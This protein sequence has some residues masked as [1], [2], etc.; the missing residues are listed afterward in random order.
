MSPMLLRAWWL[1]G[2]VALGCSCSP[3]GGGSFACTSDTQC[4]PNGICSTG[5]CA[6]PDPNC[7]SQFRFGEASGPNSGNCVG[8]ANP[9]IDAAID[10]EM[11]STPDGASCY[12]SGLVRPCFASPPAG[13]RTLN[14]AIDT[15]GAMCQTTL[16]GGAGMCVIA[17]QTITITGTVT[18]SGS[19]PLVLVATGAINVST[20]DASSHTAP[21]FVGA[22]ANPTTGCAGIAPGTSGGGAGGTFAGRGGAGGGTNATGTAGG[23][24]PMPAAPTALVGGCKGQD[25]NGSNAGVGGSGG[26]AMFLIADG[27]ITIGTA[28]LANGA[29][30]VNGT[31]NTSGA[32]GGGAGGYIGLDSPLITNNGVIAANGGG[33]AEGSGAATAGAPGNEP[34]GAAGAAAST[35]LSGNGGNGGA[36][37]VG[38]TLTG[39]PGANGSAT[40]GGGGGGG[41][42][43]HIKRLR[44][45]TIGG[46]G[47]ESPPAT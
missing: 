8:A 41:G 31:T 16:S 38:A 15:D 35:D 32:G 6:F 30:G 3:Y 47:T 39:S 44:A 26:G 18:V 9:D 14:A 4:A 43:G 40:G 22:A 1:A 42:A 19:K 36:G 46:A 21:A 24:A 5:F 23:A 33:G 29:A 11:V 25:G 34:V 10:A 27:S 45:T 20:L 13:A 37:S 7:E 17:A 12:G 2:A 28:L